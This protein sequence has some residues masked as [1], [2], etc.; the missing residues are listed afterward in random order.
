M[1]LQSRW[2]SIDESPVRRARKPRPQPASAPAADPG[3]R[4]M[5]IAAIWCASVLCHSVLGFFLVMCYFEIQQ[6]PEPYHTV[7][8]W[9]NAKGKDVLKIGAPEEGPPAKGVDEPPKKEEPPKAPPPPPEPVPFPP[10]A[11][12]APVVEPVVNAPEPV[13]PP[14]KVEPEGGAKEPVPAAPSLGAGASAG[15]PKS[16]TPGL[17]KPSAGPAPEVTEEEIDKDPTA[18]IRRRRAGTLAKLREGSQR[19][20]V[21]VTGAYDTIQEVLDRLEIPYSIMEPEQLPRA[22]LTHCKALLINCHNTY[23]GGLFRAADSATL[24]KEIESLEEKETALRKRVQGTKDKK[25]VFEL[26]L[27][28]LKT[29][30][31]LS[32]LRQQLAA[33]TGATG[34]VENVRKFVESGGYVFTSDWGLTILERAFP[35][36]VKN[37]GNIGPRK[38]TLRPRAGSKSPLLDEVFYTGQKSGTVVSKKMVWEVDSGSYMIKVEKPSVVEV[39]VETGDVF[40][41]SGV[42]VVVSPEKATGKVLHILSHF[43]RQATQQG[44]YALQNLLLNFLVERIK[45]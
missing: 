8:I 42:A 7:T 43:Q 37:G 32:S 2:R 9:R 14:P 17:A 39:I 16:D 33:F 23:A 6:E 29:T 34:M 5:E 1:H 11:P 21:V 15:V 22:D 40:R 45:K 13:A 44:D 31:E 12:P 24:Q 35:G 27:E 26:G 20:I 41:N 30:S 38:V 36:T 3:L 25:K 19:D 18:A 28:L 10:S 4:W